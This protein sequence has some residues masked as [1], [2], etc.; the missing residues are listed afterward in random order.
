MSKQGRRRVKMEHGDLQ[1]PTAQAA[2]PRCPEFR[3]SRYFPDQSPYFPDVTASRKF[4]SLL[5]PGDDSEHLAMATYVLAQ[6]S[7]WSYAER[8]DFDRVLVQMFGDAAR[9]HSFSLT[10]DALLV[11]AHAYLIVI[12]V[13]VKE[14]EPPKHI[15]VLVFRGTS[16]GNALDWVIDASVETTQFG[17]YGH[18]HSGFMRNVWRLGGEIRKTLRNELLKA[19]QAI[20]V[21]YVTGHSLGGAMAAVATV[22]LWADRE[23]E[24][25]RQAFQGKF[26]GLYTFGAPAVGDPTMVDALS[27][28]LVARTYM[29][30]YE[31]DIVPRMPP[32][33][34][35]NFQ[36]FG[37][38]YHSTAEGWV[39]GETVRQAYTAILA[40]LLGVF[41][42][43]LRLFT[44]TKWVNP[45][46][47]FVTEHLPFTRWFV[48]SWA[49]HSPI[50][51]LRCSQISTLPPAG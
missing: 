4:A 5:G 36:H 1:A 6:L 50:N 24:K 22:M 9:L 3:Q 11:N 20:D 21:L 41:P 15:G 30:V 40:N 25:L 19:Q 33:S 26:R 39:R 35:G 7:A 37:T 42:F 10:N 23:D 51:Y 27:P 46:L 18:V 2:G 8:K 48:L 49:D 45:V 38:T 43:A 28:K 44:A 34:T 13:T 17:D 29:H 31:N 16:W 14:S 47:S 12:E 32:L